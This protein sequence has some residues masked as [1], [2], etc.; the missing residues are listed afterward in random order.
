[1]NAYEAVDEYLAAN[2]R[3]RL[4]EVLCDGCFVG[5]LGLVLDGIVKV[6]PRLV[7]SAPERDGGLANS[8]EG[9]LMLQGVWYRFRCQIFV[10]RGGQRF[11][12]DLSEFTAVEWQARAA[13]AAG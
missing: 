2:Y 11:L 3:S 10:D 6:V 1:M 13:L 12:S 4:E 9:V 8:Y 7:A 5:R